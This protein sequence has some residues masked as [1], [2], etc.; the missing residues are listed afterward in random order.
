MTCDLTRDFGDLAN[1]VPTDPVEYV[2]F[3]FSREN[4]PPPEP[5]LATDRIV[6][7]KTPRDYNSHYRVDFL[8]VFA[9]RITYRRLA[10]W[11][12]ANLF[13]PEPVQS[14]LRLVH[15]ASEIRTVIARFE[16]PALADPP[17]GY[18][19][20][21][22]AVHYF[23]AVFSKH[24]WLDDKVDVWDLPLF[25]F[26]N[27]KEATL[28]EADWAGRD[29]LIGFGSGDAFARLAELLLN[30]GCPWN[31]VLEMDLESE[32]GFRGVAPRSAEIRFVLPGAF[33]WGEPDEM[34]AIE[35]T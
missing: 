35:T 26:T 4:V 31:E 18:S 30:A 10:C 23:P 13:H 25:Q 3:V 9:D 20:L 16:H 11:I 8:Q 12:L 19:T 22:F 34:P 17:L 6:V 5:E 29:T 28:T 1:R 2:D 32:A 27:R 33:P 7:K 15:P 21:P 24:P 14:T